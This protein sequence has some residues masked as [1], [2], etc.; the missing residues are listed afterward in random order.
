MRLWGTAEILTL[1]ELNLLF[2]YF[3]CYWYFLTVMRLVGQDNVV[4]A[5]YIMKHDDDNF[6]RLD[7]VVN[8][9]QKVPSGRSLYLGNINYNYRPLRNGK[10]AVSYEVK[11]I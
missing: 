11:V 4:S 2:K 1:F 10:W 5:K 3:S 7:S 9:I 8:E 6:V